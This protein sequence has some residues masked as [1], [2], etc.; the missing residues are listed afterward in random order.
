M[1]GK[2]YWQPAKGVD[3]FRHGFTL[4]IG[5]GKK[6]ILAFS[7]IGD[8]EEIG[9]M[10]FR[11]SGTACSY[12]NEIN[13]WKS[14]LGKLMLLEG[15]NFTRLDLAV[16]DVVSRVARNDVTIDKLM[17]KVEKKHY[18]KV[19]KRMGNPKITGDT[20]D[21][22]GITVYVGSR[23]S[24]KF[25]RI[26]DKKGE[27]EA[28]GELVNHDKW[29][30]Y[31]VEL[32]GSCAIQVV[33]MIVAGK[34]SIGTAFYRIINGM[35]VF[36][37]SKMKPWNAWDKLIGGFEGM[38]LSKVKIPECYD[39]KLQWLFKSMSKT[40]AEV[41]TAL[42]ISPEELGRMV[43]DEGMERMPAVQYERAFIHAEENKKNLVN[44]AES[45][46]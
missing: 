42:S 40:F 46:N 29:I 11:L 12:I 39:K 20:G 3:M 16:D 32:K 22:K 14:V 38:K 34:E 35:I 24:E 13:D 2:K 9:S 18:I 36:T 6:I 25:I 15:I 1:N 31:E 23:E 27:Q 26:Y 37:T 17:K 4:E 28:K 10:M 45:V 41:A 44:G 43:Y 7:N 21:K 8:S 19:N 5:K 33:A 30:R